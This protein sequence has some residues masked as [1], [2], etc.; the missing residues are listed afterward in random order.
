MR[1]NTIIEPLRVGSDLRLEP[2]E[3]SHA[4]VLF[5]LVDQD[6]DRLGARLPW[7]EGTRSPAD[8]LVFIEDSMQR[9]QSSGSGDWAIVATI[10]EHPTVVGV[11]GLHGLHRVHRRTAIGYWIS[12]NHEG[13]GF[14]TRSA[15]AVV[16]HLF[17][18][19][20]H[21]VEIHIA[22]DNDRSLAVAERLGFQFEGVCRG[23]EFLHGHSIDHAIHARLSTDES[24]G[25]SLR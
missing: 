3:P 9:R 10:A 1:R 6:R 18:L 4:E 8:S 5:R 13:R 15:A 23:A 14:I 19:D 11:I 22:T 12:G 21:R 24:T 20:F 25:S 2:V 17:D 7:V 16:D